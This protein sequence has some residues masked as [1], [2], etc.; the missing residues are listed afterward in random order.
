MDGVSS[1]E[2]SDG[3]VMDCLASVEPEEAEEYRLIMITVAV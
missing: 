2:R 1:L 3:L